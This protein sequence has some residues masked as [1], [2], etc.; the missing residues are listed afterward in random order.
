[1]SIYG[2]SGSGS[3]GGLA[4]LLAQAIA[5]R[6]AQQTD[7]EST[8]RFAQSFITDHDKDSDGLL[9]MGE[10]DFDQKQF[11]SIDTDGDG[12]LSA[13]E[14]SAEEQRRQES[15]AF[16]M[17]MQSFGLDTDKIA[18]SLISALDTDSDGM[19]SAGESGLDE[20]LFG[21][22]DADGDG[23]ITTAELTDALN[24][25]LETAQTQTAAAGTAATAGMPGAA[26]SGTGSSEE[27]YDEL[28]L[29]KDGIVS[30]DE[31]RQAMMQ[32]LIGKSGET[33]GA[34]DTGSMFTRRL[35]E[36]AYGAQS[37][38]M[39]AMSALLTSSIREMAA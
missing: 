6:Q 17:A 38:A 23:A 2:V 29:N 21:S 19:L 22:L 39:D 3:S 12:F 5:Q 30:A 37:G 18:A 1:M 7:T 8:E 31:L 32:G 26:A 4:Q 28:D 13:G 20:D 27:E 16:A 9:A 34:G 24:S 15:G 35:A 11:D 10:T 25:Q 33:S 14:L 36:Q